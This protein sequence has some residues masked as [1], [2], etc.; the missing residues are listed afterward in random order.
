MQTS[1]RA[2]GRSHMPAMNEG[3]R[4]PEDSHNKDCRE[5][6]RFFLGRI[7]QSMFLLHF[8]SYHIYF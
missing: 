1:F 5:H 6:H 3:D 8:I 4:A 7:V 2:F